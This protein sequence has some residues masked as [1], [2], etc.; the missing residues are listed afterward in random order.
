MKKTLFGLL[1]LITTLIG[2][3]IWWRWASRRRQLPCPSWLA[4]VL[5][6]PLTEAVAG[7]QTTLDRIGLQPG[8]HVLDVGS[9]PGRLAIPAAQRV[10]S[11]GRVVALDIQSSMLAR[12]QERAAE[13]GVANITPQLADIFGDNSLPANS[14]DRAW[15]V[16]VLG[17]IPNREAALRNLWRLLKPGGTLSITEIFPDPHYQTRPT[18]LN[19][20]QAVGFEPTRYWGTPLAFTQNFVKRGN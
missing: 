3:G 11:D 6:N 4:G 8:E 7:T 13:A 18:V 12:L 5:D 2:A 1:A 14:F 17:E 19:L 16:T 15:L 10:G 20:G 9:G